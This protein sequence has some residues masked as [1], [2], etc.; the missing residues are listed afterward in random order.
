V[1]GRASSSREVSFFSL[2]GSRITRLVMQSP[3]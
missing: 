2:V 1:L 3:T